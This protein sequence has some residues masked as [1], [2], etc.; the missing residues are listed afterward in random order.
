[1]RQLAKQS[2]S[3][4]SFRAAVSDRL[5]GLV[6][7]IELLTSEQWGGVSLR[8]VVDIHLQAFPQSREQINISGKD[9]VLKPDAVQNLGLALHELAT[10]SVKY[11]A[12]SVPQGRVR[13]EWRDVSEEDKPDALLRFTG[14]SAAAHRSPSSHR[15]RASARPLSKPM[16]PPPS[17]ARSRSI[18]GPKACYGC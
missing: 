13:F 8:R 11:G 1:M 7:S 6:R 9:F 17:A 14:K 4:E 18:S 2:D 16:P 3:V 12:L 10:N 5:E 15:A